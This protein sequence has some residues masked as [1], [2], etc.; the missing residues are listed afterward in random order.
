[1]IKDL[2]KDMTKYLPSKIIGG[3]IGFISIPIITHLFSPTDYG[4]YSLVLVA[5][6]VLV[7]LIL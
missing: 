3:I 6:G 2:V 7:L 4:N 5:V 1:M